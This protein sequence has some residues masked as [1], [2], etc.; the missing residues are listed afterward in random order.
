MSRSPKA[1]RTGTIIDAASGA[2]VPG[3]VTHS[4]RPGIV[5]LRQGGGLAMFMLQATTSGGSSSKWK[6]QLSGVAV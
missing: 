4:T 1:D 6:P 2:I 5:V 3:V